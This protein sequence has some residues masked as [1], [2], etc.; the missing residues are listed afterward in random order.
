MTEKGKNRNI[1]ILLSFY[2]FDTTMATFIMNQK[3][4][5]SHSVAND[6]TQSQI[7]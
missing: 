4:R 5:T 6:V 1:V 7:L 2:Q 3:T